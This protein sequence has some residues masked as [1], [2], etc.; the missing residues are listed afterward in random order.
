MKRET[1]KREVHGSWRKTQVLKRFQLHT[2]K[3]CLGYRLFILSRRKLTDNGG[4]AHMVERSLRMREARGLISRTSKSF[5]SH[6]LAVETGNGNSY[7]LLCCRLVAIYIAKGCTCDTASPLNLSLL[8]LQ[9]R[10][11]PSESRQAE[12]DPLAV[13]GDPTMSHQTSTHARITKLLIINQTSNPV[14]LELKNTEVRAYRTDPVQVRSCSY[15]SRFQL[16]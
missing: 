10:D 3:T 15:N 1:V 16:K 4:V 8:H 2:L 7:R 14:S 9:L 12:N 13:K 11:H 5:K 6:F